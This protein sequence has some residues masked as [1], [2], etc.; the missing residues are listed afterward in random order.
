MSEEQPKVELDEAAEQA[1]LEKEAKKKAEK[2]AQA[3]AKAKKAAE[4]QARLEARQAAEKAKKEKDANDPLADK[5]GDMEIIRS[6]CDPEDRFK[7]KYVEIKD[8]GD[9]HVAQEIRIR[10]R[11]GQSRGKGKMCFLQM[12]EG[13][14]TVQALVRVE[15]GKVS[16][17]MCDYA[18]KI[19]N[20]SIVEIVAD[21][22]KPDEPIS[23]CSQQVELH[24]KE[25]KCVNK[26]VPVLPFQ[27][28]DASRK[29]LD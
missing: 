23:G 29:V 1:R 13:Y 8:I 9:E 16:K 25:I 20:E 24:V 28:A 17:G 21:V 3:A 10:G 12:R 19:P 4:K 27:I 7:L 22:V 11:I 18:S 26:S 5:Y 15:E 6:Q 14:A 2:E